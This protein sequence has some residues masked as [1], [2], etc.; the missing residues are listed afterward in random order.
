MHACEAL[1]GRIVRRPGSRQSESELR[2]GS[3]DGPGANIARA[4]RRLVRSVP[5]HRLRHRI[6]DA[7]AD[8]TRRIGI[9]LDT[10]SHV[11]LVCAR[12]AEQIA[13]LFRAPVGKDCRR[14]R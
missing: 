9:T 12:K 6:G 13:A 14:D 7:P 4:R 8:I 5:G 11:T 10:Y 1:L 2:I 3:P